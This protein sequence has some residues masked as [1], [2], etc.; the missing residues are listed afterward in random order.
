MKIAIPKIL[1]KW[2]SYFVKLDG[3]TYHYSIIIV[4]HNEPTE[5][6][7]KICDAIVCKT[8][9][10][11]VGNDELDIGITYC[12]W[13]TEEFLQLLDMKSVD[14]TRPFDLRQVPVEFNDDLTIMR[15]INVIE[16][17]NVVPALNKHQIIKFAKLDPVRG[18]YVTIKYNE[19][20][21]YSLGIQ[22][23]RRR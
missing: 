9:G 16:L 4:T 19:D 10:W 15:F 7:E 5:L 21:D 2:L 12:C 20:N 11:T 17:L 18:K 23:F 6:V 22:G 14:N 13:A 1:W 8:F 3:T